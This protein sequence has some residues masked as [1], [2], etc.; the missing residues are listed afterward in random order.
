MLGGL[1]L[2]LGGGFLL[3]NV[4][5]Y[6]S[7]FNSFPDLLRLN[8]LS[9]Q[10]EDAVSGFD[11]PELGGEFDFIIVGGGS[12]GC[13]L[14]NRLTRDGKLRVLLLERG[15]DPDPLLDVPM[16]FPLLLTS[17]TTYGYTSVP[18]NAFG[19]SGNVCNL[20]INILKSDT[21]RW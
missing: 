1:G 18:Q 6:T 20:L 13:L 10:Q 8:F 5:F 12:A 11:S 14:A 4:L 16:Y 9:Q 2:R 19:S 3:S 7:I 21:I 15:G 17:E